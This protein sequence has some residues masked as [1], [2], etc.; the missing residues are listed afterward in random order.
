MAKHMEHIFPGLTFIDSALDALRVKDDMSRH[1]TIP[2]LQRATMAGILVGVFYIIHFALVGLFSGL[3]SDGA[4]LVGVGKLLGSMLFGWALTF[5]YFTKSELLTSN[6]MIVSIGGYYRRVRWQRGLGIMGLCFLGNALG[7]LLLA[8]FVRF[9]TVAD[10]AIMEAMNHSVDAKLAYV[11]AGPMGWSD[12]FVRAILC[13]FMINIAMLVVYSGYLKA[14]FAKIAAIL[15]AVFVFVFLGLEHSVA[16]TALFLMVGLHDG[17]AVGPAVVNVG[18]A[19]FG[20]FVGGGLLIG[21]YY[22]YINDFRRHL[23]TAEADLIAGSQ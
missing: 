6:M 18:I 7:G 2:Y 9:S 11:T 12:V 22:A 8:V 19:L 1:A 4:S 14:D 20:N 3:T 15:A 21:A 16:N 5:I 23:K 10:G 13:N 17:I